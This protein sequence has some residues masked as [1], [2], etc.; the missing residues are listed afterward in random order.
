MWPLIIAHMEVLKPRSVLDVGCGH[1]KAA[2]LC[3]E[4]LPSVKLM[5]GVEAWRPYVETFRLES[6][7]D[8]LYTSDITLLD[9]SALNSCEV[10]LMGDV[11]EHLDKD[12][13]LAL[14]ARTN[15]TIVICTPE[16][17]FDNPE[18]MP[19]TETHRSHWVREDFERTGRLER[20]DM[21]HAGQVVTLRHQ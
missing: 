4:Y 1:G 21:A 18:G 7:Y 10:V 19:W 15:R 11:I 13:A 16:H 14:L 17:F 20:Y 6:L 3:R 9:D 5:V 2:V 8:V 12:V